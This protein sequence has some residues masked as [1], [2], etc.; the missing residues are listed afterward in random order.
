MK[1]FAVVSLLAV[2][3]LAALPIPSGHGAGKPAI[4]KLT[5][6]D[7]TL[8]ITFEDG[9]K[10][11]VTPKG[12]PLNAGTYWVKSVSLFKKD[13][14]GRTWELRGVGNLGNMEVVIVDEGQ[15][16]I[17]DMGPPIGFYAG[18]GQDKNKLDTLGIRLNVVGRYGE[19][20][21]PE[22][23]LDARRQE[24]PAFRIVSAD[25]KTVFA[26]R[27][28]GTSTNSASYAWKMPRGLA[29]KFKLEIK[30]EIGPFEWATNAG[31]FEIEQVP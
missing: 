30:P 24:P 11:V 8:E 4:V 6:P 12:A 22:A 25:G 15:E 2:T 16:K 3:V 31:E 26:D 21:L 29:G 10:L 17:L 14:D 1:R 18:A 27:F 9:R 19:G 7:V 13:K 23:F 28:P 5:K 20:Y